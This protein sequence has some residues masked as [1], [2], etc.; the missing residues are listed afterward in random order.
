M[1][2]GFIGL[3][4]MG[5]PMVRNLMKGGHEVVVFTRSTPAIDQMVSE[6]A[7]RGESYAQ[8]GADCPVII[9]MVPNAPDVKNVLV[10]ANGV[11]STAKPGTIVIDMSS[12]APAESRNICEAC[13]AKGVRMMDAPV[14]GGE[15]GAVA[16]TLSIMCGGDKAL[17]DE[18]RDIL[19]AMGKN[20]V[21]CGESGAGNT[22]KLVNQIIV[23]GNIAIMSE[24]FMLARQAGVDPKI[25]FEAVRGGLAGSAIMESRAPKVITGD[26]APTFTVDLHTKDLTNALDTGHGFGSPMPLTA[27]VFEMFQFLRAHGFGKLDHSAL[28]KF[29]E[30]VAGQEISK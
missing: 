25:A 2:I 4:T 21:Y 27:Q 26:Y 23:A 24:G 3:G 7:V 17:F 5:K 9:T 12:I 1:K 29:Y 11:L 6:G 14:S 19:S 18:C 20:I 28:A 10:G 22:V 8:I 30:Q 15:S 16:G 13:A